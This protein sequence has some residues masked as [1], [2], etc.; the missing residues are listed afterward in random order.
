M[1]EKIESS[2]TSI[3]WIPSEAISGMPKLPFE[4]GVAHYDPPP[5]EVLTDLQE[6][7]SRDA[8]RFANELRAWIRVENGKI[9][10]HG[11]D[12]AGHIGSTT[13][14]LGRKEMT[15]AA[16]PFPDIRPE[17]EVGP[18]HVR[19]RQ[20]AGGR[21]GAPAPRLIS[22]PPFV[23]LAAPI[24][25]TSLALTM[26]VDGS[27]SIDV[28]GASSFP[29][30][31]IY[32]GGG[33]LTAKTGLIDFKKWWRDAFNP[34][35]PWGDEHAS[36]VITSAETAAERELSQ[37]IMRGGAQ[38]TRRDLGPGEVLLR[39]GETGF[40]LFLL[41]DGVLEVDVDGK[42]VAEVG[43]GAI[44]GER[45][46]LGDGRRTSTLRATTPVRVVRVDG[47]TLDPTKLEQVGQAH[48]REHQDAKHTST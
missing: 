3:S 10:D 12:G 26:Y 18:D 43:P 17:P 37:L 31:W 21:T 5:P 32:D 28:S 33:R 25:W 42:V 35:I 8:F 13:L 11:Q 16:V 41:L 38:L 27:S 4:M 22:S 34:K 44:V 6:L 20:T 47:R 1:A 48:Q 36:A 24:A 46:L 30:H 19:F 9:V 2:T 14:R 23:Q 40:D 39:Q 29:R 7:K 45:A 15:F